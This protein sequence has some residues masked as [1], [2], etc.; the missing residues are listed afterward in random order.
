M[1]ALGVSAVAGLVG[2]GI[3][4]AAPAPLA[5]PV[6]PHNPSIGG[7]PD[8]AT[9]WRTLRRGN[10]RFAAGRSRHPH[11]DPARRRSLAEHQEPFACVL[12]CADSRVPPEV[13]FDRGLGD[14]FTIRS[15][16]EVLDDAVLGSVEYAVHH[17]HVPLL[18]VL[19]HERCGAVTAAVELVQGR[20]ELSGDISS[21]VRDIEATVRATPP[22]PDD[23]AF[24]AACVENQAIQVG[25][26]MRER[27]TII[28]EAVEQRA[29]GIVA[30]TYDLDS[31]LVS[32]V[33]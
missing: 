28:R 19:G 31:G 24:L 30:A 15:A 9:A 23:E 3:S 22:D 7:P 4:T 25:T 32:R 17:L 16:G 21:L 33:G 27:S 20:A 29:L 2:G 11:Q 13:V 1:L 18:V 26:Q 10:A 14:L 12:S 5:R 8:A 6:V